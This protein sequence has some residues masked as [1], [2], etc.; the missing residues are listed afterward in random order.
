M[1]LIP[2]E[3][4]KKSGVRTAIFNKKNHDIFNTKD[5]REEQIWNYK[6]WFDNCRWIIEDLA[7]KI[8]IHC[9]LSSEETEKFRSELG[10]KQHDIIMTKEQLVLKLIKDAF[11]AE[12]VQTEYR[13]LG[14]KIDLYFYDYK[15]AI[16]V[17]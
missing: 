1:P 16:E 11:E 3:T 14:H 5:P 6:V 13:V 9:R 4:W 10:F 2:K 12:N 7:L 17:D 8:M 15:L